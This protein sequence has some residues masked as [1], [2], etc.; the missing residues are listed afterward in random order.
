MPPSRNWSPVRVA[1]MM[2]AQP[3]PPDPE[4]TFITS[5]PPQQAPFDWA[6]MDVICSGQTTYGNE[7]GHADAT[8]ALGTQMTIAAN[9]GATIG[10]NDQAVA[11]VAVDRGVGVTLDDALGN[12]INCGP[13]YANNIAL[14]TFASD[15]LLD[16]ADTDTLTVTADG[17]CLMIGGVYTLGSTV[18]RDTQAAYNGGGDL[19]WSIPQPELPDGGTLLIGVASPNCITHPNGPAFWYYLGSIDSTGSF[20]GQGLSMGVYRGSYSPP[21]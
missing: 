14:W 3:T 20:T 13:S 10:A 17:Q 16:H 4:Q 5:Q 9:P 1:G 19:V 8:A 18:S 6:L 12:W 15:A 2:G 11:F 21:S 7:F